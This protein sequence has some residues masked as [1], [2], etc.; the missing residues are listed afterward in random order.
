MKFATKAIHI[1]QEP[2]KSTGSVVVPIYQTSTYA[3][4]GV[5]KSRGYEYSRTANP[6]RTALETSMA[7]LEGGKHG[8]AFASG[9]SAIDTAVRLLSN[10]DH[11]VVSDDVYGGTRRLFTNVMERFGLEFTFVDTSNLKKLDNAMAKNTKMLWIETPTNPLLKITDLAA[12]TKIAR[13]SGVLT[14]V[15]NTFMSPYFQ[16]PLQ[17]GANIVVHSTTK[18]LGG[19]SDVVGGAVVVNNESI[20]QKLKFLQNAAGAVPGPFDCWLVLRGIR[21]LAARMERHEQNAHKIAEFLET[22]SRVGRVIYPG[23]ASHPQHALARRQMSGFGGI[24]SFEPIG[25]IKS[26]RKILKSTKLFTLAE[27]LGGV[28]SL[29]SLPSAMTHASV[30]PEARKKIGIKDELIRLSVGIED[31]DDLIEDLGKSLVGA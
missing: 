15:D 17:L 2:E 10:G 5:D 25:G 19:H 29:I 7:A 24:I 16:Q 21:T 11:V 18:Y 8:L 4:D 26:A 13:R 28:E 1:G 30:P 22:H 31:A 14:V 20:Y 27:S 3:Q 9:M 12:A 6:T 23:L